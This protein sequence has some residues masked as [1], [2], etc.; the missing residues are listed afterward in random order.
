[1]A[2]HITSPFKFYP[3]NLNKMCSLETE[4]IA[5]N[6]DRIHGRFRNG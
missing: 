2:G 3:E 5:W 1:M 6:K 4:Q